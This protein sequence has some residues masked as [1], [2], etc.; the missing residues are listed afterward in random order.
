MSLMTAKELHCDGCG[1]WL[2]LD[3]DGLTAQW[4]KLRKE[5]WTR[6]GEKHYCPDCG[7]EGDASN[8]DQTDTDAEH[9]GWHFS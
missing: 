1:W 4:S 6:G 7:F 3:Y 2:R 5:G 8:H 9:K